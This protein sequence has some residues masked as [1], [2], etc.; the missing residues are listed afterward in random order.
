MVRQGSAGSGMAGLVRIGGYR[1]GEVRI[2][3]NGQ[4]RRGGAGNGSARSVAVG[5][6]LAWRAGRGAAGYEAD[7]PEVARRERMGW[8]LRGVASIGGAGQVRRG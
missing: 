6:G 2:G 5:P 1:K 3:G 8:E 4:D 7:R